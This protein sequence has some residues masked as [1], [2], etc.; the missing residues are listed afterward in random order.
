MTAKM[1]VFD[2][3]SAA[4]LEVL[5]QDD[6]QFDVSVDVRYIKSGE[7]EIKYY[8]ENSAKPELNDYT[9]LQKTELQSAAAQDAALAEE[10]IAD[11]AETM[12]K[13]QLTALVGE[14]QTAATSA[15]NSATAA[16]TAK[17][18]AETAAAE[19]AVDAAKAEA[20]QKKCS[21]GN[22][23]DIKYTLSTTVPY[24][25]VWCDGSTYTKAQFP[26]FYAKLL[27]G[28]IWAHDSDEI[29]MEEQSYFGDIT[30]SSQAETFTVPNLSDIFIECSTS[31]AGPQY[32][33]PQLPNI[34]ST[35]YMRAGSSD[36]GAI[37]GATSAFSFA[38]RSYAK[39]VTPVSV[40]GTKANTD[41]LTFNAANGNSIYADG[42]TVQ[43]KAVTYRAYLVVYTE[44]AAASVAQT[45]ELLS[46]FDTQA[47]AFQAKLDT[48]ADAALVNV[49][50]AAEFKSSA[51]SWGLPNYDS[52][53]SATE[54]LWTMVSSDSLVTGGSSDGRVEIAISPSGSDEAAYVAAASDTAGVVS[55]LVPQN[56]YYKISAVGE[57]RD[58]KVYPLKGVS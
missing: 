24:G 17:S 29:L 10:R 22:L 50:P 37:Y 34:K 4:E 20:A 39:D 30:Y 38:S 8:V 23:G 52:A 14:S 47:I 31:G 28:E 58:M 54:E 26:D 25:G 7:E 57:Y 33:A 36:V 49:S 40:T 45:A 13:P 2:N 18:A 15:A 56:W 32:L 5:F 21:Y 19:A 55:A 44:A 1:D 53:L 35:I 43:P 11:Y 3:Y 48:K 9:Q 51:T 6:A 42:A 16:G 12:V 27:S 46:N 41:V